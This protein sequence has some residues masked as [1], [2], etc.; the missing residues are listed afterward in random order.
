MT[1]L[2]EYIFLPIKMNSTTKKSMM[3]YDNYNYDGGSGDIIFRRD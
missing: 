2:Q 3:T 1:K